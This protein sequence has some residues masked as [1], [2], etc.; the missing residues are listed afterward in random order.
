MSTYLPS[1]F[2]S[3]ET[4]GSGL[5]WGEADPQWNVVQNRFLNHSRQVLGFSEYSIARLCCAQ[6]TV[7]GKETVASRIE[8]AKQRGKKATTHEKRPAAQKNTVPAANKPIKKVAKVA[9]SEIKGHKQN[10]KPAPTNK[11]KAPAVETRRDADGGDGKRKK[12]ARSEAEDVELRDDSERED[13]APRGKRAKA[14]ARK[15]NR[16][17]SLEVDSDW[18]PEEGEGVE[19]DEVDDNEFED[20]ELD[21][22]GDEIEVEE[23][24]AEVEEDEVEEEDAQTNKQRG[25]SAKHASPKRFVPPVASQRAAPKNATKGKA[26][27]YKGKGVARQNIERCVYSSLFMCVAHGF[28][29]A[30][31]SMRSTTNTHCHLVLPPR[32]ETHL[33]GLFLADATPRSPTPP[34]VPAFSTSRDAP[35]PSPL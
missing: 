3:G 10:K 29:A 20:V 12:R 19:E 2:H 31:W 9:A 27:D 35:S 26:E 28:P 6:L 7:L 34:L 4:P 33:P 1:S 25:K 32:K 13:D 21:V 18:E 8:P 17:Q 23:D 14:V 16:A 22:E 11:R 30:T 15:S 24:E 5:T